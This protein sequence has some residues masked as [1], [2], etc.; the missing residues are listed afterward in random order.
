MF[1]GT[2]ALLELAL[3]ALLRLFILVN[4]RRVLVLEPGIANSVTQEKELTAQYDMAH[5][6][7]RGR[8]CAGRFVKPG[9]RAGLLPGILASLIA[10]RAATRAQLKSAAAPAQRTMLD[11]RQKVLELAA[12]AL[13]DFTGPPPWPC[14]SG[15]RTLL[16]L[17]DRLPGRRQLPAVS[18][19]SVQSRLLL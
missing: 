1:G 9:V 10:A 16:H 3:H 8:A 18:A 7:R 11:C 4:A 5:K 19:A 12:N 6:A 13:Y 17:S 14:K 15:A 2:S